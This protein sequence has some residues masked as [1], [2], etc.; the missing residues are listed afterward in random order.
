MLRSALWIGIPFAL[1]LCAVALLYALSPWRPAFDD[2]FHIQDGVRW[3]Q[4]ARLNSDGLFLRVPLWPVMLGSSFSLFGVRPGL[5]VLQ[6]LVVLGSILCFVRYHSLFAERARSTPAWVFALPLLI[7]VLSPQ[8]VL[9]ARHAVNEL[10]IGTLTMAVV[11]CGSRVGSARSFCL[12]ALVAAAAMT[13]LVAL[14][15]AAPAA[16]LLFRSGPRRLRNAAW[17]LAGLSLVGA[18]LLALHFAQH[19]SLLLDNTG[20]Y[21]LSVFTLPE[22]RSFDGAEARYAA[23]MSSFW[24]LIRSDPLAYLDGFLGRSLEWP[25]HPSSADFASFFPGYPRLP[26]RLA[27]EAVFLLLGAL[28]AIGTTR[29]SAPIWLFVAAVWLASCFP[30]HTPYT[31]KLMLLFPWLLLAPGG[32]EKLNAWGRAR[33]VLSSTPHPEAA[34]AR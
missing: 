33:R 11:L 22:W 7:F 30:T 34:R 3:M 29:R 4:D 18:P 8:L 25:L 21:Q 15:L 27:D 31:P 14:A 2:V 12:G 32:L 24:E 26:I 13:K 10:W 28:A 16:L 20:A 5:F 23:G 6:A 19:G 1:H 17:S 9:Y